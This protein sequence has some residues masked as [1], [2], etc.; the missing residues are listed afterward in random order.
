MVGL[1]QLLEGSTVSIDLVQGVQ[2]QPGDSLNLYHDDRFLGLAIVMKA[3]SRFAKCTF[4]TAGDVPPLVGDLA[5]REE[6]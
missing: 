3:D 1:V 6:E 4:Q 5:V 2:V